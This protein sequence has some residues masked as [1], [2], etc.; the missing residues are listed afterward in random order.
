[1]TYFDFEFFNIQ[2][3]TLVNRMLDSVR[4]KCFSDYVL[5]LARGGYQVELERSTLSPYVV[6]SRHDIYLDRTREKFLVNYLKAYATILK[7]DIPL[8]NDYKEYDL[9]IQMMIYAQIWESHQFLKTL[10]RIGGI[11]TGKPYNWRIQFEELKNGKKRL[12]HK[13]KVIK[14][15]IIEPLDTGCPEFAKFIKNI[16]DSNLRNDFAHSSYYISVKDNVIVS[17]DSERYSVKKK[18]DLFDWEHMFVHSALL[19]YHLLHI[20]NKRRNSFKKDYPNMESVEIEWPSHIE[21]SKKTSKLL[22]PKEYEWGIGF[23]FG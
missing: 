5:L 2:V 1:M 13:G 11:L 10:I 14:E 3:E 19:S 18:T 12:V 4:E 16:Y 21:P 20:I 23:I 17:M 7:E 6:L 15:Q 8:E 22:I 9:N